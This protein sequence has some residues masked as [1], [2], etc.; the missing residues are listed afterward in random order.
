MK[1]IAYNK[2]ILGGFVAGLSLLGLATVPAIASQHNAT[3]TTAQNAKPAPNSKQT[4]ASTTSQ[5]LTQEQMSQMMAQCT[6]MMN[7]MQNGKGMMNRTN[8]Q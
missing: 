4:P 5:P 8:G 6:S 2:A 3:Q 7:M 1:L